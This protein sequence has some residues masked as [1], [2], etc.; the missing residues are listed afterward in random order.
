MGCDI[1]R[2][3]LGLYRLVLVDKEIELRE[4]DQIQVPSQGR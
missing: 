2:G 3:G 1:P 4:E